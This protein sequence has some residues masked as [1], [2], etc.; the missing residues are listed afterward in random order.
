VTSGPINGE[1][2]LPFIAKILAPNL[3]LGDVV[4]LNNLGSTHL[5]FLP[6]Y[7][8]DLNPMEQVTS[9]PPPAIAGDAMSDLLETAE[10]LD[11]EVNQLGRMSVLLRAAGSPRP[12]DESLLRPS[13]RK[14]RLTVAGDTPTSAAICPVQRCGLAQPALGRITRLSW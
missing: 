8:A 9:R 4:V 2:F 6:S 11:V 1:T 3:S 10:F 14:M 7:G 5:S 13:R 12:R